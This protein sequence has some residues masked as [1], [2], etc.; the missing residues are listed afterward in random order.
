MSGSSYYQLM[1]SLYRLDACIRLPNAKGAVVRIAEQLVVPAGN[2]ELL[3]QADAM[4]DAVYSH[5][6]REALDALLCIEASAAVEK[7]SKE[8]V[9]HMRGGGKDTWPMA[10]TN[11]VDLGSLLSAD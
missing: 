5:L 7:E 1:M 11:D 4:F 3:Q 6:V 9:V 2:L 10:L 8:M